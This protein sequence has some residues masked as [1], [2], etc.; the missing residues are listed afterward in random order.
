MSSYG[1][2]DIPYFPELHTLACASRTGKEEERIKFGLKDSRRIEPVG[3]I[4]HNRQC[5]GS[6]EVHCIPLLSMLEHNSWHWAVFVKMWSMCSFMHSFGSCKTLWFSH[7]KKTQLRFE[8]KNKYI[9]K[10]ITLRRH[11]TSFFPLWFLSGSSQTSSGLHR[12]GGRGSWL[13]E[14]GNRK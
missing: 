12:W 10:I 6:V 4:P 7:F 8:A 14:T 3:G 1:R 11:V 9:L 5:A 2:K 13:R